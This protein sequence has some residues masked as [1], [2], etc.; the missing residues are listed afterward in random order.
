MV[1]KYGG[2]AALRLSERHSSPTPFPCPR[3]CGLLYHLPR[4]SI[5]LRLQGHVSQ[6]LVGGM[7]V[8]AMSP[9]KMRT[10]SHRPCGSCASAVPLCGVLGA[11]LSVVHLGPAGVA[12]GSAPRAA[13][14]PASRPTTGPAALTGNWEGTV[15]FGERPRGI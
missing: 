2:G 6:R 4:G 14:V 8:M 7:K 15:D 10:L 12:P 3:R 13:P 9:W 1:V 5:G 11:V